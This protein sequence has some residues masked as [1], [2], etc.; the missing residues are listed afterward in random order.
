MTTEI[1]N[2]DTLVYVLW[3]DA[4]FC[5]SLWSDR[6]SM[7]EQSIALVKSVGYVISHTKDR[8]IIAQTISENTVEEIANVVAIPDCCIKEIKRL[9]LG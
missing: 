1:Y 4:R 7:K 5:G 6:Q 2:T 3:Q 8:I 9:G